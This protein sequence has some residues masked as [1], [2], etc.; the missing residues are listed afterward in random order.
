MDAEMAAYLKR[1][2]G[3]A[4][5]LVAV[6][7]AQSASSLILSTGEPVIAMGGFTGSDPA[8]TVDLLKRYAA[9]GS[10]RYVL[11]GE[12]RGPGGGA[13]SSVTAWVKANA[14]L[15]SASEYGGT[16]TSTLYRLS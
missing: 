8:M 1:N 11:L 2:K 15:V 9:D 3:G 5:W 12:G 10:L 16:G 6:A 13:G 7:S 4:A 14:T